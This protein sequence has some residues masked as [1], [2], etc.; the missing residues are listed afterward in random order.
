M[1]KLYTKVGDKGTT[2]LYDMSKISKTDDI[3]E[4]LGSLDELS[5][6]IGLLCSSDI[7][8]EQERFL[9]KVQSKL[10]DIGSDF[11]T[12]Y[13]KSLTFNY[14]IN[15][16]IFIII[17][18]LYYTTLQLT[19]LTIVIFTFLDFI[20][21]YEYVTVDRKIKII[22]SDDVKEV[23]KAIDEVESFNLPLKE[24]ILPG[25]DARDSYAH[26]CRS[27]TRRCERNMWKVY[28]H[29]NSDLE[30]FKFINRLSDYFFAL[31]RNLSG[32]QETLRS[33]A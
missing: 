2:N 4:V 20:L 27:V 32:C 19:A 31:A 8:Q 9:R 5:S 17:C 15:F 21:N 12:P 24:F 26:V 14:N 29:I 6:F 13:K 3:V 23:E 22:T 11:A 7:S 25:V 30:K 33:N 28:R 10:L 18:L 16:Y 1:V